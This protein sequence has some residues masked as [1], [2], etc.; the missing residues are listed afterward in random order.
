MSLFVRRG[1]A[2]LM[3]AAVALLGAAG[4]AVG[5]TELVF[6]VNDA[7]KGI[8]HGAEVG[9]YTW[10]N[11]G[12]L[13]LA[14]TTPAAVNGYSEAFY[15]GGGNVKFDNSGIKSSGDV[16]AGIALFWA[17]KNRK[18]LN[19]DISEWKGVYITYSSISDLD[20]RLSTMQVP[21]GGGSG[22]G[23]GETLTEWNEYTTTLPKQTK[24]VR[25]YFPFSM[26]SQASGWGKKITLETAQQ[27]SHG[28]H[29]EQ[30]WNGKADLTITKVE[31]ADITLYGIKITKSAGSGGSI[32]FSDNYAY[33]SSSTYYFAEGDSVVFTATP[34]KGYG[35]NKWIVNGTTI[36]N[37]NANKYTFKDFSN[38]TIV[39]EVYFKECPD[40]ANSVAFTDRIIPTQ[41]P[42]GAVSVAP[43]S[44]V[45]AEFAAGPNP[46]V[47]SSG[48]VSFF[49]Q[50][51]RVSSASLTIYDASGNAV[52]KVAI[53]DAAPSAAGK[54]I[55]GS[56]DLKDANGRAVPEGTYLA[57]GVLKTV[58]GKS[59][60]VAVA[61]GIR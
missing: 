31:L 29:I 15:T 39:V 4:M 34:N 42:D 57:R 35:I 46:T 37:Y 61:V 1:R 8:L 52:R 13:G 41:S 54:R 48:A 28:F 47:K 32:N 11:E 14:E 7:K 55:I 20:L 12:K 45:T 22:I 9:I 30:G 38:S 26:F 56:W 18:S 27:S 40:C 53:S 36:P 5:E 2:L 25:K 43:V 3:T 49:R 21:D 17:G 6:D 23:D 33:Y 51:A 24:I 58:N 60:Q 44:C 10:K 50:G 16:G 19:R 59:E